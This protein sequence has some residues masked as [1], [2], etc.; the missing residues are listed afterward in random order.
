MRRKSGNALVKNEELVL[1]ASLHLH[2]TGEDAYHGYRLNTFLDEHGRK[3]VPSTLYRILH[4]LEE[5]EFMTSHWEQ[6]P[7]ATQWRCI[8]TLTGQGVTAAQEVVS[9]QPATDAGFLPVI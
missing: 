7:G 1:V 2:S 6:A 9:T 4:R 8:F 5:R 3:L